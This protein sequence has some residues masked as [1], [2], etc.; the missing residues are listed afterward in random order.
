[1]DYLDDELVEAFGELN[2]KLRAVP[3]K[4]RMKLKREFQAHL[5]KAGHRYTMQQIM[6]RIYQE[7]KRA[8]VV[9]REDRAKIDF[10]VN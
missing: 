9:G 10:I 8:K 5:H 1:M 6:N 4:E 2:A 3:C 7:R